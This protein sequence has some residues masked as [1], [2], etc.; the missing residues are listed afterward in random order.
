MTGSL[1]RPLTV[2]EGVPFALAFRFNVLYSN[3][4][5]A[6]Q[7]GV[8]YADA[9]GHGT[10]DDCVPLRWRPERHSTRPGLGDERAAR[11]DRGRRPT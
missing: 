3:L 9:R 4:A 11:S 6:S 10:G 2:S 5:M 1:R 7:I 8:G